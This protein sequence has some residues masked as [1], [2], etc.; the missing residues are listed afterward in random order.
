[1]GYAVLIKYGIYAAVLFVI[2]GG[3]FTIYEHIRA[4]AKQQVYDE[5]KTKDAVEYQRR[6]DV[7]NRTLKLIQV[8][9]S[10]IQ[11]NGAANDKIVH[12]LERPSSRDA[13]VC[14]DPDSVRQLNSIG[15]QAGRPTGAGKR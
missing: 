2:L 10:E 5:L 8:R 15:H 6:E 7:L 14:L 4:N 13:S 9:I 1:M 3:G 12:L 11:T